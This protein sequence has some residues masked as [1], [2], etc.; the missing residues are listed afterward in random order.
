MNTRERFEKVRHEQRNRFSLRTRLT[1][2]V[3]LEMLGCILVSYGVDLLFNKVF[4][5]KVPLELELIGVCLLVGILL[6]S[7][8]SKF[9]FDPIKKLRGA[10]DQVAEGDYSVRLEDKSSSKEIM[11]IYT[12]FYFWKARTEN[13]LK[14]TKSMVEDWAE[15]YGID[16]V[17]NLAGIILHD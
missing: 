15:K 13:K 9:F 3:T 8:L 11:E 14:L 2:L 17:V 10:M 4:P 12:G 7:Q 6:T 1:A 16:A 5:W